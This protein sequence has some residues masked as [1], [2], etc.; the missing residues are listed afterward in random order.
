MTLTI[1]FID[2]CIAPSSIIIPSSTDFTWD[3]QNTPV[4][5][6]DTTSE[7]WSL[8]LLN[9]TEFPS[10][11]CG[12]Y[13]LGLDTIAPSDP[14]VYV[15]GPPSTLTLPTSATNLDVGLYSY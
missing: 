3:I 12:S 10:T 2:P 5:W 8:N 1:N 11:Y 9:P 7:N 14:F 6:T 13:C 4:V 15:E